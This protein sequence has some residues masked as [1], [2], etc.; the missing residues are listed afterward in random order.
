[1]KLKYKINLNNETRNKHKRKC[2]FTLSYHNLLPIFHF[3]FFIFQF[4]AAEHAE[5]EKEE[6]EEEEEEQEDDAHSD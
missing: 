5:L 3:L 4:S 1:M 6:E 2:C